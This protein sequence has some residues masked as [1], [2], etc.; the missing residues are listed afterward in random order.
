MMNQDRKKGLYRKLAYTILIL[1]FVAM[2]AQMYIDFQNTTEIQSIEYIIPGIFGGLVFGFIAIGILKMVSK[3][4]LYSIYHNKIANTIKM[5][6]YTL[7]AFMFLFWC[8]LLTINLVFLGPGVVIG[9]SIY[10]FFL[11][12]ILLSLVH[13]T[14]VNVFFF[15][16]AIPIPKKEKQENEL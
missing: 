4:Q 3:L 11:R 16:L 2:T 8:C 5:L 15:S 1:A 6:I 12:W 7:I 9:P 13:A 10:T 14:C